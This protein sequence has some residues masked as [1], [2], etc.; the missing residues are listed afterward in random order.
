MKFE[1]QDSTAPGAA[2]VEEVA[3]VAGEEKKAQ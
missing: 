3:P 1:S 2:A